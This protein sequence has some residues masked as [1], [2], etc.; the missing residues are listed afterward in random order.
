MT[1]DGRDTK[2][3]WVRGVSG[4][5]HGVSRNVALIRELLEPYREAIIKQIVASALGIDTTGDVQAL[6]ECL[7][8]LAPL[9]RAQYEA[10]A[11]PGLEEAD[12]L[13]GKA[14]AIANAAARGE[15]PADVA[16]KLISAIAALTKVKES[17]ELERRIAELEAKE[18][19]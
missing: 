9:P 10:V 1:D 17:D 5:P 2:G 8:R 15:I 7:A 14:E 19:L 18:L 13:T 6:K 11:I 12:T 16:E 4:N 3:R